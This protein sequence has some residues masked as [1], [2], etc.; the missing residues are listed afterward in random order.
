MAIPALEHDGIWIGPNKTIVVEIPGSH[1]KVQ[2]NSRNKVVVLSSDLAVVQEID[3]DSHENYWDRINFG[4]ITNNRA[5][6]LFWSSDGGVGH[7]R[8]CF[9]YTGN[10]L[11]QTGTCAEKDLDQPDP[12]AEYSQSSLLPK[13]YEVR[14]FAGKSMDGARASL[15]GAK[16]SAVCDN[17]GK[18]CP[19]RGELIVF[20]PRT[21]KQLFVTSFP[22][23]GR[24]ALSPTGNH[25]AVIENDRLE[26]FELP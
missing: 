12:P 26:I 18:F 9:I 1:L 22:L 25:V 11:K 8:K 5:Q 7:E 15:F 21:K 10:P 3:T 14:A 20:D 24:A 2:P 13:G 4:G 23:S 19:T 16:K 17:F 6:A